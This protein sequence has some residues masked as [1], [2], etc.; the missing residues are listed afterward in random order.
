LVGVLDAEHEGATVLARERPVVE[1]GAGQA[2]V[3]AAGRGRRHPHADGTIGVAHC[4]VHFFR[5]TLLVR[6]PM[7][8]TETSTSSPTCM[9]PTPSG[10]PVRMTSPGSSVI[11]LDTCE[12]RVG[13]SKTMSAVVPSCTSSPFR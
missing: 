8:A 2:D 4:C 13:M 12:T 6:E 10:V 5:T 9:G 1:G 11:T 7:P 3:R